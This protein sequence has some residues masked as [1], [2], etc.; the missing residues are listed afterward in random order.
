MLG[1]CRTEDKV[2]QPRAHRPPTLVVVC[3]VSWVQR[4]SAAEH[5]PTCVEAVLRDPVCTL[6]TALASRAQRRRQLLPARTPQRRTAGH[7]DLDSEHGHGYSPIVI[8]RLFL[9]EVAM[10]SMGSPWKR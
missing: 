8:G 5:E 4:G 1:R 6:L 2:P 10:S 3:L 7:R 9:Q